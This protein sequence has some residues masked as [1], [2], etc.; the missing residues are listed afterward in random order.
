MK[1]KRQSISTRH[2]IMWM[3]IVLNAI[4]LKASYTN[5]EKWYWGLTVT[6]P[7]LALAIISVLK[8]T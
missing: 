5:N 2:S 6:V 3:L 7:F 1:Q 4:I 8:K